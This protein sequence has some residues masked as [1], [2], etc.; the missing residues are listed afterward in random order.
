MVMG[1][2]Q[3][4]AQALTN[5]LDNALKYGAREGERPEIA[6]TGRVEGEKVVI[7]VAD[8]GEGIPRK[9]ARASP[10][11]S[12]ASIPAA[13]SPATGWGLTSSPA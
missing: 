6:L 1:D 7:T 3:L 11:A 4:L 5:L 9:T 10:S 2:R 12:S 13:P 8:H